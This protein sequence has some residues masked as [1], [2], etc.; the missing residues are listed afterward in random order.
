MANHKISEGLIKQVVNTPSTIKITEVAK[1][2]NYIQ[3][4]LGDTHHTFLQGSYRNNTAINDINDVDIV[5]VRKT[6]YSAVHSPLHFGSS[7]AWDTIFSEI[8]QKLENQSLYDWIITRGDKCIK[9][10]GAFDADVVPAV[11]IYDDPT[12]DPIVVYSFREGIEKVNKPHTHYDNGVQKNKLTADNFK[13]TV[14]MF[15]NWAKNKFDNGDIVSSFQ[16]EALV[17]SIKDE[18]FFSD[19]PTAF[20]VIGNS[21]VTSMKTKNSVTGGLLSVCGAEDITLNWSLYAQQIFT[22]KLE[23]SVGRALEAYKSSSQI[24]ANEKWRDAFGI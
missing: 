22:Q 24:E 5:A 4:L 13:P 23:E 17:H 6:T 15:K 10:S 20:P 16:I 11:Q 21:I 9:I 3:E 18:Y 2:Q 7:I 14:R 19:Y 8:E 1:L 12:V